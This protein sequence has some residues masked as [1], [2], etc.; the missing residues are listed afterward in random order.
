MFYDVDD[1]THPLFAA[2]VGFEADAEE[3]TAMTVDPA[4]GNVYL[5]AR[6]SGTADGTTY[7]TELGGGQDGIGDYDLYRIDFQAAYN[8]WAANFQGAGAGGSDIYVTYGRSAL[9]DVGL[10]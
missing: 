8:D 6:D 10:N 9:S 4:T 1:L 7:D 2:F 3:P 5:M